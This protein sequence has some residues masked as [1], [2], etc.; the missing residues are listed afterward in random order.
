MGGLFYLSF[1]TGISQGQAVVK[2]VA[3][4]VPVKLHLRRKAAGGRI[5][6]ARVSIDKIENLFYRKTVLA[7]L[8]A[9]QL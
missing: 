8:S 2:I 1:E 9:D 5:P 3:T 4:E 7:S 6:S